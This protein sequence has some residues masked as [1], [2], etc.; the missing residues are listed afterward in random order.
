MT[1]KFTQC[2]FL[3]LVVGFVALVVLMLRFVALG[4]VL[5]TPVDLTASD[6]DL[7]FLVVAGF[8]LI[9]LSLAVFA[10]VVTGLGPC[11]WRTDDCSM[12]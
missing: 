5:F 8:V 12:T 4:F 3:A 6:F 7:D 9:A 10:L 1:G 11:T 2:Y